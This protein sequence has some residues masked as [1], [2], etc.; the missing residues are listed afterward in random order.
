[1]AEFKPLTI[2]V[3]DKKKL[4]I[5]QFGLNLNVEDIVESFHNGQPLQQTYQWKK[6]PNK[7]IDI[8]NNA[9]NGNTIE[10]QPLQIRSFRISF[11]GKI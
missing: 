6:S 11:S 1:M 4:T 3:P 5:S 8:H 9:F 10:L 2:S 7:V